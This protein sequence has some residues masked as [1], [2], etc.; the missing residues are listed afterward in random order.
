MERMMQGMASVFLG[1]YLSLTY[2]AESV[3]L[4]RPLEEQERGSKKPIYRNFL[5]SFFQLIKFQFFS[6]KGG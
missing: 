5:L 3:L 6:T 4:P 2:S 1:Y